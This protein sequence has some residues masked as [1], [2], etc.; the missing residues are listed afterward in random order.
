[1]S[2]RLFL[3][4]ALGSVLALAVLVTA[5]SALQRRDL[6]VHAQR[7]LAPRV[8]LVAAATRLLGVLAQTG[9]GTLGQSDAD[10]LRDALATAEQSATTEVER[11][12]VATISAAIDRATL[13]DDAGDRQAARDAV[14]ALAATATEALAAEIEV[15]GDEAATSAVGLGLLAAAS[16]AV[17]AWLLRLLRVRL[18]DRLSAVDVASRAILRGD[19]L[20]RVGLAGDDEIA[21]L[22]AALD[23]VIDLR[24][25]NDAAMRGRNRELRAQLVAL[26]RQWPAPAAITGIDGE[27]VVSTLS[28]PAQEVLRSLTPQVRAAA[29]TLLSRGIASAQGLATEVRVASGHVVQLR[30]LAIGEMRLVGWLAIVSGEPEV[31]PTP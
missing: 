12:H 22:G 7:D 28:D 13:D 16:V 31:P 17:G 2:A 19:Q 8:A 14:S 29:K 23:L 6:A 24:D 18:L 20:R 21:A 3:R 25:R 27:I 30:G 15:I 11:E 26:L 10:A 1:M 4:L 9:T 5:A